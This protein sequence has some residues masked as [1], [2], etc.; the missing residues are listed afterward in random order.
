M[1]KDYK[2]YAILLTGIVGIGAL[3]GCASS[4][5]HVQ[6]MTRAEVAQRAAGLKSAYNAKVH[7]KKMIVNGKE[8]FDANITY[9][10]DDGAKV[11][12]FYKDKGTGKFTYWVSVDDLRPSTAQPSHDKVNNPDPDY[13]QFVEMFGSPVSE[14][15]LLPQTVSK[16]AQTDATVK[17]AASQQKQLQK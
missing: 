2:N 4:A 8:Y 1:K 14:G 10:D 13:D 17:A 16:S 11:R 15:L 5:S 12:E 3:V 6:E 7:A 9:L